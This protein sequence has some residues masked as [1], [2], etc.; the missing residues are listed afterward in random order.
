MKK[1]IYIYYI[2][3]LCYTEEINMTLKINYTSI[4][5]KK[6]QKTKKKL[7]AEHGVDSDPGGGSTLQ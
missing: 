6:Q 3:S 4:K 2:L 5:L 7:S 1:N